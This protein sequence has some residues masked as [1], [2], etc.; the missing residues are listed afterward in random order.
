MDERGPRLAILWIVS[1]IEPRRPVPP[2]DSEGPMDIVCFSHLKWDPRLFQ[3][4][5]QVM[6]RLARRHRVLYVKQLAPKDLLENRSIGRVHEVESGVKLFE[7]VM[8]PSVVE[9]IGGGRWASEAFLRLRVRRLLRSL[10]FRDFVLWNYHPDYAHTVGRMGEKLAVYDCMDDHKTFMDGRHGVAENEVTLLEGSRVVYA[11]GLKM[12]ADRLRYQPEIHFFPCGVEI[13]HFVS[14]FSSEPRPVGT[15]VGEDAPEDLR[16]LKSPILGYWG[17]VDRRLDWELIEA[18]ARARRAWSIVLLG[19]RVKLPESELKGVLSRN[20]NIHWLGAR[21]YADLP[22]YA[23]EWDGCLMPWVEGGDAESIN[24]TKTLEY[25]ATGRPVISTRI[26]DMVA[27]YGPPTVHLAT[28]ATDFVAAVERALAEDSQGVR[29]TRLK[30]T[31]GNTWE[32]MVDGMEARLEAA[33]GP[34]FVRG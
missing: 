20:P 23:R 13:A 4:P 2:P 16:G 8:P 6:S 3:R 27:Q 32:A 17:A 7:P 26:H 22:A 25:L 5:Q 28:G 24:P 29:Q 12:R 1:P 31:E 21:K 33:L 14:A 15:P 34:E 11:G 18:M 30:L 9:R 19:P 10:G